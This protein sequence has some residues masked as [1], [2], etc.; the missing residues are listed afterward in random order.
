VPFVGQ[1]QVIESRFWRH[2]GGAKASAYGAAPWTGMPGNEEKD[3]KL[4]PAGYT[5]VWS[6]GTVG[7][8]RVPFKSREEAEA[9]LSRH[10]S[11]I[12]AARA[13]AEASGR[14]YH[15]I[16]VND[17]TGKKTYLTSSP[18]SHREAVTVLGKQSP[19]ARNVRKMLEE[20]ERPSLPPGTRRA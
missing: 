17:R 16:A 1:G 15:V 6:D 20:V 7:T 19:S 2:K 11:R 10:W 4:E 3:W 18:L 14:S 12:S 8:G 5:I 13:A 9:F